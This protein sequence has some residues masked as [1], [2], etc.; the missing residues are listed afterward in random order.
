MR[1]VRRSLYPQSPALCSGV[2]WEWANDD[3]GWT[4][5]EMNVSLAL[6][7]GSQGRQAAVDLA[8]QG[9]QYVVDFSTFEQI[10][11][12]SRYRRRVRRQTGVGYP[13]AN[14]S[15]GSS[16]IHS[17]AACM[18]QQC[19][20]H[21]PIPGRSRNSFSGGAGPSTTYSP[22]PRR[23]LSVGHMAFG[24]P[25]STPSSSMGPPPGTAQAYSTNANGL[26]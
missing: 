21:G 19:L 3:G 23:P 6:E 4:A 1:S 9:H 13:P 15:P 11:K 20:N 16:V 18:C 10:N 12:K 17:G 7:H 25:W 24:G 5:Y 26:R 14:A 2:L 22:Y 8:P